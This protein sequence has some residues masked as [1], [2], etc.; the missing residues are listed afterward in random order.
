MYGNQNRR[1][2]EK[3]SDHCYHYTHKEAFIF[4]ISSSH[5]SVT[6][7]REISARRQQPSVPLIQSA[8]RF[9]VGIRN[10]ASLESHPFAA[11]PLEV[12]ALL[13]FCKPR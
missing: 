12:E 3:R 8:P 13:T 5:L 7:S 1:G 4:F 9:S 6:V 11:Q 2:Y 10:G